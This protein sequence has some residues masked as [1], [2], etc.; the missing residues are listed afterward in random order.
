[1]SHHC[2]HGH[3]DRNDEQQSHP[4]GFVIIV[5]VRRGFVIENPDVIVKNQPLKELAFYD[6]S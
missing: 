3:Q 1:L 2:S 4:T 5:I 6:V